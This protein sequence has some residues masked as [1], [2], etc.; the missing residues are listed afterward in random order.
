VQHNEGP[1][2]TALDQSDD[3]LRTAHVDTL[4][5]DT[6]AP[7]PPEHGIAAVQRD[8]A[9]GR[10]PAKQYRD[11]AKIFRTAHKTPPTTRNVS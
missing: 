10:C 7:E 9:F 6:L 1:V 2:E 3:I 5:I 11:L 4:G 8:L